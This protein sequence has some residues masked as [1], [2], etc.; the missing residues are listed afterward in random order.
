MLPQIQVL[1]HLF[2]IRQQKQKL[3]QF[4]MILDLSENLQKYNST[5]THLKNQIIDSINDVYLRTMKI[6][7]LGY[8][9]LAVWQ[10]IVNLYDIA[11]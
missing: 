1:L 8:T 4:V 3:V 10:I 11:R 6:I 2:Q 7:M 9:N 5:D